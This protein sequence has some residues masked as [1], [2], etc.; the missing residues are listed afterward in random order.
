[1]KHYGELIMI[2]EGVSGMS[3]QPNHIFASSPQ[4]RMSNTTQSFWSPREGLTAV[5]TPFV[6]ND[7]KNLKMSM[8]NN[9]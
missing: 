5:G 7:C 8:K 1:M 6:F 3:P 2:Q 9:K 4:S